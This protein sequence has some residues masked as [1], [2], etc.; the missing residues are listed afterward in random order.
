V[1]VLLVEDSRRLQISLGTG[2]RKVGFSV[3]VTGDGEEGLYL[4]ETNDYD[5]IVLDLMLPG[6]DGLTLLKKLRDQGSDVHILILTARHTV[7]ERVKGLQ[8]GADDY[9]TKPFSFDELLARI[10]ALIRRRYKAKSP[11]MEVGGLKVDTARKTVT[12]NGRTIDLAPREYRILEYLAARR[13]QL[14][15]RV[16]IE[17]HV[18]DG[19]VDLISNVVDSAICNLR[20]KINLPGQRNLIHTRRG[21]GYIMQEADA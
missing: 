5:V 13:G 3:D 15:S 1:K 4:A 20:K 17:E 16:E 9:L 14:V 6:I 21:L 19:R 2:L 10:Q 7:E 11:V 12:R 18:Y 8:L